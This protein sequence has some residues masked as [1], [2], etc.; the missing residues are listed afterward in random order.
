M[1]H[2][3]NY[4]R[5]GTPE[6]RYKYQIISWSAGIPSHNHI[7]NTCCP[8]FSCCRPNLLASRE[9]VSA[10][11]RALNNKDRGTIDQMNSMFYAILNANDGVQV[12]LTDAPEDLKAYH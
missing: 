11:I 3:T 6:A 4:D 10:F 8:D 12:V 5:L 2:D 7:D 9:A 1:K